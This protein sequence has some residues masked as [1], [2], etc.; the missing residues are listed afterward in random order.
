[1]HAKFLIETNKSEGTFRFGFDVK[2]S[3]VLVFGLF[4]M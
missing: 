3:L 2:V 1:M 4:G